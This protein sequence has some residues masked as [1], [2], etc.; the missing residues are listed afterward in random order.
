VAA[1]VAARHGVTAE[2]MLGR[3]QSDALTA[4]RAELYA[5][6]YANRW[7]Y[8]EIARFVNRHQSRVRHVVLEYRARAVPS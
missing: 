7:S 1:A 6:L 3:S 4:A 2:Q 5:E 8:P